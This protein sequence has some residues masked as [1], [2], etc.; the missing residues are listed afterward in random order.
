MGATLIAAVVA[1][2][3][4][5]GTVFGVVT[6]VSNAKPEPVNKPLVVYGER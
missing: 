3:L 4:A 5:V 6:T 2:L 1:C